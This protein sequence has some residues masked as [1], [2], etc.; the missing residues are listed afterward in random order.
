MEKGGVAHGS[1]NWH[2]HAVLVKS[3]IKSGSHGNCAAH[4]DAGVY[5]PHGDAEGVAAD[6]AG[7]NSF[8]KGVPHR[9]ERG[10]VGAA[11]A[12]F[13]GP[14]NKGHIFQ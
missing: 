7:E 1:D 9:I 5:C 12:E 14:C 13:R 4:I 2:E 8:R 10:P 6:I 11:R 3:V